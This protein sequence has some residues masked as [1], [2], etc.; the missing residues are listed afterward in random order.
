MRCETARGC[1]DGLGPAAARARGVTDEGL[2]PV[3]GVGDGTRGWS[4]FPPRDPG[5]PTAPL[6]P[7]LVSAG[8]HRSVMGRAGRPAGSRP[9]P[10]WLLGEGGGDVLAGPAG[11]VQM[12]PL[13]GRPSARD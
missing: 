3:R 9:R 13:F 11:Q 8:F 5:E 6:S 10:A 7:R 2:A 1:P 4:E 12:D